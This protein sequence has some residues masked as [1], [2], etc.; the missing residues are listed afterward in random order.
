MCEL[1]S[2]DQIIGVQPLPKKL[3]LQMDNCVKDNK[4]W[5]LLSFLSLLIVKDFLRRSNW[6]SLWLAIHMRKSTDVFSIC[7]KK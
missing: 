5:H 1:H 6:D 4:N 3:L 7:E 2:L